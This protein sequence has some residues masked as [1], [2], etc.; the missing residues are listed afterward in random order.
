MFLREHC[1]V[2]SQQWSTPETSDIDNWIAQ[3]T[4]RRIVNLNRKVG[5]L[6]GL[7]SHAYFQE[8]EDEVIP[9]WEESY[10]LPHGV[11]NLVH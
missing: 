1:S 4:E 10:Y 7:I 8:D 5:R 9:L 3:L 6:A 2:R 11:K